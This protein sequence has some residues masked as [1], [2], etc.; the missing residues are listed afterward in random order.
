MNN[1]LIEKDLQHIWHPC[2]RMQDFEKHPP[3][4]VEKA[5]GSYIY[6]SNGP[7]IDGISSWWCKSLGHGH[8]A[9]IQ[10]I[11]SQLEQFEH[12]IGANTTHS[13]I[14]ELAQNLFHMTQRQHF[15]FASDGSSAV[16]I[17]LKLARQ[18]MQRRGQ[19]ERHAIIYLENAYHGETQGALSVSD[20]PLFKQAFSEH[21]L[22]CHVLRNIPYVCGSHDPL[23]HDS[24]EYWPGILQQLTKYEP[25]TAAIIV[26]P[27][28]QG[29][30]NMRCYSADFLKK[31]A[32]WAKENGIY[33]IADEI[34]TGIGRTG[35][36]LATDHAHVQADM[37]CLSKG[38]TSGSIPLSIVAIDHPIYELFYNERSIE[39]SFLHSHTYS[40]NA[41]AVR[42]AL[43]TINTIRDEN[44]LTHAKKLSQHLARCFQDVMATT[45]KME[46][47]RTIGCMV[48]AD[49][50]A[51][52]NSR[53]GYDVAIKAQNLGALLRPI[54]NTVYWLPPLNTDLA[55]IDSLAEIT[56]Q[57]IQSAY[58]ERRQ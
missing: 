9:V 48:A 19:P 14:V 12:V 21:A 45:Q 58:E 54:G 38:L 7:L 37:I 55:V 18:A 25:H 5:K 43:A 2:T 56:T 20:L 17:S 11:K 34:M 28:V 22:P 50:I 24:S 3:L 4:I 52:E 31:L 39:G 8:P 47:F 36:W 16:E 6:T 53:L 46:N 26:E 27:I 30:G 13:H 33:L 42:A 15:Y 41:L 49:L 35:H 57:A 40:G 44:I 51:T 1:L 23:W 29:A 10:A 32:I